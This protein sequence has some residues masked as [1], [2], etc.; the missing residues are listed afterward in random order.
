MNILIQ[1]ISGIVFTIGILA[2]FGLRKTIGI[3]LMILSLLLV[4]HCSTISHPTILG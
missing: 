4:H 3:I 1:F 2:I